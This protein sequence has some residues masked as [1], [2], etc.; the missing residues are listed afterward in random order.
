MRNERDETPILIDTQMKITCVK[1]ITDGSMF[2][3]S[4]SIVENNENKGV[5][6]F[7]N[8]FGTHLKSLRVPNSDTVKTF[9]FEGNGLRIVL[10]VGGSLYFANLKMDHKW[11]WI[12]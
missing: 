1:W 8:N 11:C 4:G 12:N 9:S 3:V 2:G 10:G 7:Y 5:V 6:Q